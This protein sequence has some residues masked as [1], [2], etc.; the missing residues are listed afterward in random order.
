MLKDERDFQESVSKELHS[1]LM[2]FEKQKEQ[3]NLKALMSK[4]LKNRANRLKRGNSRLQTV[5][6]NQQ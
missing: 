2:V 4:N 6:C 5:E 1:K 3:E